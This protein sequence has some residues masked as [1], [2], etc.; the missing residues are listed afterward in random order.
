MIVN[1]PADDR[2]TYEL[3]F[4]SEA[5]IISKNGMISRGS[6]ISSGDHTIVVAA[7]K[8]RGD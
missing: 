1:D 3:D 4:E 8:S 6:L 7:S 2:S 5:A